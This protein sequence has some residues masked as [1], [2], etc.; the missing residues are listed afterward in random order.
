MLQLNT[1]Q[2]VVKKRKRIGRGGSRGG[3]AGRGHKGQK[4]RS[5]AHIGSVFEGGQMPLSRRL[6]K[7][8]FNNANF[9]KEYVIVDLDTLEKAFDQNAQVTPEILIERGLISSPK[10][11]EKIR[12]KVLGDGK[13]SKKLNVSAHGF[14]KSAEQAIK[15]RGGEIIIV[16]SQDML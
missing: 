16:Q 4:A 5:G 3:T 15:D 11:K 9:R 7:R 6:P 10:S 14:S 1:L 8:G 2:S 13:L 12:V